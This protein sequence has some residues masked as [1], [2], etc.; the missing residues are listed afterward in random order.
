MPA[1]KHQPAKRC[2]EVLRNVD[3]QQRNVKEE[4]LPNQFRQ[5]VST[6]IMEERVRE[7]PSRKIIAA[8]TC[9]FSHVSSRGLRGAQFAL[10]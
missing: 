2:S 9:C 4:A 10:E 6:V 5:A 7:I 8:S 3:D 1:D